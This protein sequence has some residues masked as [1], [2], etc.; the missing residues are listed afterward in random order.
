MN[1]RGKKKKDNMTP[2]FSIPQ[3][4]KYNTHTQTHTLLFTK[5]SAS[6]IFISVGRLGVCLQEGCPR[7]S[8]ASWEQVMSVSAHLGRCVDEH[9][10]HT[11]AG[12]CV[13]RKE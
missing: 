1:R 4:L 2:L 9:Q 7:D 6:E 13:F 12:S 5:L 10:T 3:N 11:S 8:R